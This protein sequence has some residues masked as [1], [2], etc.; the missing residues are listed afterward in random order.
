MQPT[1]ISVLNQSARIDDIDAM[2][3]VLAIAKQFARDVAPVWGM[4][5]S[6]E[7]VQ[8]GGSPTPGAC[9]CWLLDTPD[10]P[11]ALGYH[12]E[13]AAGPFI[14]VFTQPIVDDGGT[15][16]GAGASVASVLSHEVLEL[17]G[18]SAANIWVDG[19]NG[20]DY[21]RELCDAVQGDS[22]ELDGVWVSNFVY[23]DFFDPDRKSVV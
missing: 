7:F 3:M 11:N 16:L 17:T 8:R 1:L 15:I 4:V 5:P 12:D 19:P 23:P 13:D 22:Y 14:K 2:K 6:I 18:D 10:V 20:N 9:R 21:A